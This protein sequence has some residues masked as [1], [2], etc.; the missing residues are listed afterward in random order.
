MA[1]TYFIYISLLLFMVTLGFIDVRS[2]GNSLS[3]K[4]DRLIR[5]P[6]LLFSILTFTIIIGLRYDVGI[7]WK[8]YKNLLEELMNNGTTDREIEYGYYLLMKIVD[9]LRLN[10]VYIFILISFLQIIF[11][12]ARGKDFNKVFPFLI[13]FFFTMGNFIY[14]LNI[15]RQM[16][17]ISIIFY[18]TKY[19]VNKNFIAWLLIC[20]LAF[21][22][23][24]TSVICIPFYF[25]NRNLSKNRIIFIGILILVYA[26]LK[27]FIVE[28][29]EGL[30][31][32]SNLLFGKESSLSAFYNQ[33]REVITNGGSGLFLITQIVIYAVMIFYYNKCSQYYL[34]YG[35]YLFFNLTAF[36]IILFPLVSNNILLDRIVYY[37]GA[38]KFVTFGFYAHYFISIKKQWYFKCIGAVII[39]AYFLNFLLAISSGSNQCS[40]FQFIE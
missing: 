35:F 38:F 18:G 15:M 2:N 27:F 21:F 32:F 36:G 19:I 39:I 24:K 23:H 40:P 26:I 10:Y 5:R 30:L 14:S 16:I 3:L 6:L 34:N 28:R 33:D 1:L 25:L 7:D 12:Y 9:Y 8:H 29:L 20:V 4:K 13:I 31:N 22:F 37:F 11:L 17:A